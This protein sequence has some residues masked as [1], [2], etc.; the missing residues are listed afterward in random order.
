LVL[1]THLKATVSIY[2]SQPI[3]ILYFIGP[4]ILDSHPKWSQVLPIHSNTQNRIYL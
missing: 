3:G 1:D 4:W 2:C